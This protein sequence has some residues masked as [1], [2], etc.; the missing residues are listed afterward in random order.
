M[1]IQRAPAVQT[2]VSEFAKKVGITQD[3]IAASDHSYRCRCNL[4]L[5]WWAQMPDDEQEDGT[6]SYG[7]FTA[8]EVNE[9]RQHLNDWSQ[10]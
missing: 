8:A 3:F 10:V 7:P 5:R 6:V 2:F 9:A 4:C 1:A